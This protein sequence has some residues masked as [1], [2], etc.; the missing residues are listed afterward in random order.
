ASL[1]LRRTAPGHDVDE[2]RAL[3]GAPFAVELEAGVAA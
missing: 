1:V 3:T 2:I